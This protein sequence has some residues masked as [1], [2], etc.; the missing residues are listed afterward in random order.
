MDRDLLKAI[1]YLLVGVA[2]LL[3]GMRMMTSDLRRQLDDELEVFLE[4]HK[5]NH[6]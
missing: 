5:T 2:V 1:I 4:E 6:F 3:I